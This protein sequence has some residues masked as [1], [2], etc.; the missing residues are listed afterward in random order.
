MR[1]AAIVGVARLPVLIR[2]RS[3]PTLAKKLPGV[4]ARHEK[5]GRADSRRV[6]LIAGAVAL[7][8]VVGALV[9]WIVRT[10]ELEFRS[11]RSADDASEEQTVAS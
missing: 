11:D 9:W 5:R 10:D 4:R 8:G 1:R 2:A 6:V 7:S 3:A